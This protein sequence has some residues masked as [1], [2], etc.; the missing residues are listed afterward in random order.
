M[1]VVIDDERTFDNDA[2]AC[3]MPILYLRTSRDGLAYLAETYVQQ[4]MRYAPSITELWLD[5]DLGGEGTIRDVV[6]FLCLVDVAVENI[7][8]H[9]QN[10]TVDWIVATLKS[11]G[12]NVKREALPGLMP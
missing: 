11:Q 3:L 6:D 2:F 4:Q 5:H 7:Y 1:R 12:Y 8:V 9:S 10:P